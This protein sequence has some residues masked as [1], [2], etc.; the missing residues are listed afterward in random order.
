VRIVSIIG[1]LLAAVTLSLEAASG[2]NAASS[3]ADGTFRAA[4]VVGWFTAID[5]ALTGSA[6][7]G[8]VLLPACGS[9]MAY[10]AKPLP[11]GAR[12]VPELA[13]S[14]PVISPDRRRYTFVM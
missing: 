2:G 9:L 10:P 12:L 11:A 1:V 14:D 7:D 13:E 5:P 3:Q 4:T 8:T 6:V